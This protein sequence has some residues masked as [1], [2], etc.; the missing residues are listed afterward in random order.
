VKGVGPLFRMIADKA[1]ALLADRGY[2]ADAIR[3]KIAFHGIQAASARC[4]VARLMREMDLQEVTR[5]K[6]VRTTISDKAAPCPLDHEPGP[7]HTLCRIDVIAGH[8][9]VELTQQAVE[10]VQEARWPPA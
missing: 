9:E 10:A 5:G 8:V 6:P 1:R 4:T 3:E 2:D 7:G